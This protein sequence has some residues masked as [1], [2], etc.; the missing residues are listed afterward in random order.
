MIQEAVRNSPNRTK[1]LPEVHNL[2]VKT[3]VKSDK[4]MIWTPPNEDVAE[5]T[6]VSAK[7]DQPKIPHLQPSPPTTVS[8]STTKSSRSKGK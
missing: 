3:D 4:G 5:N 1:P 6:G 7:A 2:P 8:P